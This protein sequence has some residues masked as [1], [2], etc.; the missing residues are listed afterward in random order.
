M[1]HYA[2]ESDDSIIALHNFSNEEIE[3]DLS[4]YVEEPLMDIISHQVIEKALFTMQPYEILWLKQLHK[5]NKK[6]D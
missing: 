2:K 5:G 1:K 6:N 4:P 3:V